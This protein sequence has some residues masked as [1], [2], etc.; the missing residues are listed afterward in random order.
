MIRSLSFIISLIALAGLGCQ[1]KPVFPAEPRI[2]FVE[3]QPKV[4]TQNTDS[5]FITFSF[6]DGDGDIG[7]TGKE[8]DKAIYMID[9]RN[10]LYP[11]DPPLAYIETAP[12]DTSLTPNTKNPSIQGKIR[13]LHQPTFFRKP[14]AAKDKTTFTV[15]LYD[16]AGNKSNEIQTDTLT[17]LP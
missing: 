7:G 2:T 4:I 10:K 9:N 1:T 5:F 11:T 14:L 17:I 16:R 6:Q 12:I 8:G 15:Y 13:V 3:I